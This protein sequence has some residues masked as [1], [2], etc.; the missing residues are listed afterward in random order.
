[1]I[2]TV[3]KIK[4]NLLFSLNI[5]KTKLAILKKTKIK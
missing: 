4:V 5:K 1:M 2:T 3:F